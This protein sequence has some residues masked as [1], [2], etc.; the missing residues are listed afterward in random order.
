[1]A[2]EK[3]SY[4]SYLD[5][6]SMYPFVMHK[7]EYPC[8][9]ISLIYGS[10]LNQNDL[11]SELMKYFGFAQV[12]ID[13]PS[14]YTHHPALSHKETENG[15]LISTLKTW[16]HKV[17][18]TVELID[19]V[20]QGWIIKNIDWIQHYSKKSSSIFKDYVSVLITEKIHAS[21]KDVPPEI[22]SRWLSEF[23]VHINQM[24]IHF[25]AGRRQIAKLMLNS[26]WGKLSERLHTTK[27]F[28][29]DFNQLKNIELQ[30]QAG[31]CEIRNI[32]NLPN[33]KILIKV[34]NKE[35]QELEYDADFVEHSRKTCI[36]IGAYVTM[37]GRRV[38]WQELVKLDKRVM[39]HD[40]DSII[41]QYDPQKYNIPQ[42]KLLGEWESE[43]GDNPIYE[44]VSLAPKT[45]AY[46]Y[47][48]LSKA[49]PY[50]PQDQN[51]PQKFELLNNPNDNN[52]LYVYPVVEVCKVKGFKLHHD[53]EKQINF[54]GLRDLYLKSK[55][56]QSAKQLQ[57]LYD[58]T[59]LSISSKWFDKVLISDYQK[60]VL[61]ANNLSYPFGVEKYWNPV[62]LDVQ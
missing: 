30:E 26:L 16:R 36:H 43:T 20:Q 6:Q 17:F 54:D 62:T 22:F 38:L 29:C 46:K 18:T 51:L 50:T 49:K 9:E 3:K 7:F 42:G 32:L 52:L 48:D 45:Y 15:L 5:V 11:H 2:L 58:P 34:Q 14:N 59:Q 40:T 44:F 47:L 60:G 56:S 53:A 31:E 12:T 4:L 39:Y 27:T 21:G 35:R 33:G 25:N 41:F 57:F 13:P 23:G 10:T 8:G 37:Y 1:D 61:G 24:E 19:A 28:N 55:S